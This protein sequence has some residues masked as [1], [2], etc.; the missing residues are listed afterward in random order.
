MSQLRL[1]KGIIV[2]AFLAIA[3]TANADV[4]LSQSN[5]PS[6]EI[7]DELTQLFGNERVAF[8]AVNSS[9]FNRLQKTPRR[10]GRSDVQQFSYSSEFLAR[11]PIANGDKQWECLSEALYF[12][13]RGESV[14]GQFAVAEVIMNR[15]DS[16]SFPSTL[17]RVIRQGTGQKF[18]CQFT[19]TCDGRSERINDRAAWNRVAKIARIMVDGKTRELT[20]GA[21]YYHTR[22][23]SPRWARK[24]QRTVAIGAHLFYRAP[25]RTA[26]NS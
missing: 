26:T 23:V 10:G 19:Y 3:G 17:C 15:V 24:F 22:A 8:G 1:S 2:F 13:A 11:L 6:A 14:Q 25:L 9:Q 4:T 16:A 5:A 21:T 12:E 20:N 7:D 18:R